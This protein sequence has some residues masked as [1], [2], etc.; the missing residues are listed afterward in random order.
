MSFFIH[1]ANIYIFDRNV[2]NYTNFNA[3]EFY[4]F[5]NKLNILFCSISN[6][7]NY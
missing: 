6:N 5:M 4:I 7:I 3:L 2:D 1:C